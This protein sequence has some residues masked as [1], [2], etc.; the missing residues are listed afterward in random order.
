MMASM[1]TGVWLN[2]QGHFRLHIPGK[3]YIH[4]F[5]F[6]FTTTTEWIW[7]SLRFRVPYRKSKCDRWY[8]RDEMNIQWIARLAITGTRVRKNPLLLSSRR[9]NKNL[10]LLLG[11]L[12]LLRGGLLLLGG[13]LQQYRYDSEMNKWVTCST[14]ER[15][16][17]ADSR[18]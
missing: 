14:S 10:F 5:T 18:N 3:I 6:T 11:D 12:L 2:I 4:F 7:Q 17:T 8:L 15:S 1:L 13:G 9:S 16:V